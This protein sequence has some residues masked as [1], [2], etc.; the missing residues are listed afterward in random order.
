MSTLKGLPMMSATCIEVYH[1]LSSNVTRWLILSRWWSSLLF[2]YL[3]CSGLVLEWRQA[4]NCQ[5]F[6]LSIT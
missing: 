3:R 2:I 5:S 4:P 6:A 1:F